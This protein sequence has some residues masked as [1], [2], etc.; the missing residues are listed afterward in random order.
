[1]KIVDLAILLVS[2]MVLN[3]C[4]M[5]PQSHDSEDLLNSFTGKLVEVRDTIKI[6]K[7]EVFDGKGQLYDW[8]GTGDCSQEE[9]MP[10]MFVLAQGA[11][12]KN[13]WIRNAPDGVHIK[14]SDTVID[15][16]VNVD[17]CEDAIS[18][19]ENK[20]EGAAKNVKII[21][22]KFFFCS[23][24]AIQLTRGTNVVISNNEFYHCA[25]AVRIKEQASNI[26]IENN[27][28]Y[29]AKVAIKVTGGQGQAKGN[30][31]KRARVGIWV[32]SNGMFTEE[33][34]NTYIDV[35]ERHR[36]TEGGIIIK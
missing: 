26:S 10:S 3:S 20:R 25:K 27:R 12:L 31:I 33:G 34:D 4:R 18:I 2:F 35:A 22:S 14:G 15:N 29:D 6:G 24:K 30:L 28:I 5:H 36:E 17:V 8:K 7:G 23:D 21:N 13:I 32:E 16:M 11:T 9:G 19:I 1:M